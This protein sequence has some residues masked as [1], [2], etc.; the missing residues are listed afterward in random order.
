VLWGYDESQNGALEAVFN[1]CLDNGV[2]LFDTGD[3]YGTGK[4]EGQAEKLLG[5]FSR[6]RGV[7]YP[8]AERP[9]TICV[10]T[11]LAAYP[12]RLTPSS[13]VRSIATRAAELLPW[14]PG[15][16]TLTL[17]FA[18]GRHSRLCRSPGPVRSPLSTRLTA[19]QKL[20]IVA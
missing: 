4:L 19:M 15:T 9:N 18:G 14:S 1:T 16:Q 12:W 6:R 13:M 11:K 3:S 20:R 2:N 7:S 8:A 10:G 5:E 17:W